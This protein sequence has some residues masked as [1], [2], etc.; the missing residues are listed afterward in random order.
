MSSGVALLPKWRRHA[1]DQVVVR[2]GCCA[3]CQGKI[4]PHYHIHSMC[5]HTHNNYYKHT[6]CPTACSRRGKANVTVMV[7]CR[8]MECRKFFALLLLPGYPRAPQRTAHCP[9]TLPLHIAHIAPANVA[10]QVWYGVVPHHILQMQG[11][12]RHPT[13]ALQSYPITSGFSLFPSLNQSP[14]CAGQTVTAL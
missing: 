7:V 3:L 12:G 8:H 9:C 5:P 14:N 13:L 10:E 6:A 1:A 11:R 2:C 4:S